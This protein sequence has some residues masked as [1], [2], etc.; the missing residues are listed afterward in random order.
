MT[1]NSK[2]LQHLEASRDTL[3]IV[4][5]RLAALRAQANLSARRG[6]RSLIEDARERLDHDVKPAAQRAINAA[7]DCLSENQTSRN[8]QRRNERE[9]GRQY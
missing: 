5:R 4:K 9:R 7:E 8:P 1:K 2:E 6:Q 3:E